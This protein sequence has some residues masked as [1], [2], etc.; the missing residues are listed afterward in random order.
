MDKWTSADKQFLMK[1]V[2]MGKTHAQI[3]V[4]F[5]MLTIG[6]LPKT[7]ETWYPGKAVLDIRGGSET[8]ATGF[9]EENHSGDC[10]DTRTD[11]VRCE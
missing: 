11:K 5:G 3:A 6:C 1:L 10:E 4:I 2:N 7:T 9:G 8:Q